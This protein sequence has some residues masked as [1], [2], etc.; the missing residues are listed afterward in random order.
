MTFESILE[1]L[2]RKD[3]VTREKY[4]GT[5]WNALDGSRET[6]ELNNNSKWFWNEVAK[7][8]ND[9]EYQVECAKKIIKAY[10]TADFTELYKIFSEDILWYSQWV[11]PDRKGKE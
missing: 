6:Q 4:K 2:K 10:E 11:V 7:L 5:K 1:E 8:K 3:L 9:K